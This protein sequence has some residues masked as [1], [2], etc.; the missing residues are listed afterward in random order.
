MKQHHRLIKRDLTAHDKNMIIILLTLIR[1]LKLIKYKKRRAVIIFICFKIEQIG[2]KLIIKHDPVSI[3]KLGKL[4]LN[5]F[6][7]YNNL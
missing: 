6:Q 4:L 1:K 2:K 7:K 5:K 3:W